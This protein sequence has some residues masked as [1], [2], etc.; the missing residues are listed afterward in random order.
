MT[1]IA[2][3]GFMHAWGLCPHLWC[4]L[5]SEGYVATTRAMLVWVGC[6]ATWSHSDIRALTAVKGHVWVYDLGLC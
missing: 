5:V 4:M 3:K 1:H 6:D 2:T